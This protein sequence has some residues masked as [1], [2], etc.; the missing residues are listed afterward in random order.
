MEIIRNELSLRDDP[1]WT[2]QKVKMHLPSLLSTIPIIA[3]LDRSVIEEDDQES[4]F[5][6][7]WEVNVLDP[8]P[9]W[10]S[11][12]LQFQLVKVRSIIYWNEAQRSVEWY[13]SLPEYSNLLPVCEGTIV[14]EED[15]SGTLIHLKG[16]FDLNL[17]EIPGIPG[18]L[19]TILK[20][21]IGNLAERLIDNYLPNLKKE[22]ESINLDRMGPPR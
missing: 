19:N 15:G 17:S 4:I 12:Y 11:R 13:A 18:F 16:H 7:Q 1:E 6:D 9:N 3:H 10:I 20:G 8:L 2:A 14:F 21:R 5:T 22:L